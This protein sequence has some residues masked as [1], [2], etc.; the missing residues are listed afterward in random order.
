MAQEIKIHADPRQ[1]RGS[2]AARRFRRAGSV[3]AVLAKVGGDSQLLTLNAHDFERMLSKHLSEHL[4]VTL[5]VSG[6]ET[7]A[8]LREIQRHSVTGKVLHADFGEIT[9][10]H[11]LHVQIPVV[12]SGEPDGVRN[13]GGVLDQ[14][15]REVQVACLPSDVVEQFVVDVSA[16]KV[17][18]TLLAGELN[19]GERYTLLTHEDLAVASVLEA[20]VEEASSTDAAGGD[21]AGQPEVVSKAKAEA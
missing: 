7:L 19:L 20:T 14:V 11:K 12:L 21:E 3:P 4:V 10:D 6:Q 16:M 8:L 15:L 17:G 13:Q 18:D 9:R 1:T 5:S 2:T